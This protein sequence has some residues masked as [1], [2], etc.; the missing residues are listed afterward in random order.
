MIY[1]LIYLG[2]NDMKKNSILESIRQETP[3][4][5]KRE[6]DLSFYVADKIAEILQSKGMT[7][8]DLAVCLG[9]KESEISKWMTG[10]HNFTLRSIA[11]IEEVLDTSIINIKLNEYSDNKYLNPKINTFTIFTSR[12][13]KFK[14]NQESFHLGYTYHEIPSS[15]TSN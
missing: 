2:I 14:Y 12:R 11:K 5:I 15:N 8:K 7:Q 6:V 1:L 9:K 13:R 4:Y 3:K 10:T